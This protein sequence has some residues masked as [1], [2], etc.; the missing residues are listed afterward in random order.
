M[1]ASKLPVAFGVCLGLCVATIAVVMP[2]SNATASGTKLCIPRAEGRATIT[3]IRGVC[4]ADYTLAVLSVERSTRQTGSHGSDRRDRPRWCD[5][6]D[7]SGRCDRP[8]G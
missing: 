7:G 2:A 4:P 6:G 1:K 3:P 5:R 8:S